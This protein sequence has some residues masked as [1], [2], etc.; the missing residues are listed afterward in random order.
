LIGEFTEHEG[1][2]MLNFL[3]KAGA[4]LEEKGL[5]F[6]EITPEHVFVTSEGPKIDHPLLFE[7]YSKEIAKVS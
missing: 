7:G 3:T 1:L 4:M 6:P 5:Y 2:N